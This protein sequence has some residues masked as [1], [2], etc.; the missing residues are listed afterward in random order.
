MGLFDFFMSEEKKI[1]KHQ[2]T[3]TNRDLAVEDR[4]VAARWLSDNGSPKSLV[5]LLTR[6]DVKPLTNQMH[7]ESER[8]FV[9]GLLA[10]NKENL[11]RPLKRHLKRCNKVAFPVRLVEEAF[12]EE[13][14]VQ[15]VM[16]ILQHELE[17][18]D[19]SNPEKKTDL[20]VWL[21][22]REHAGLSKLAGEYLKNF[23]EHVRCAA[24]EVVATLDENEVR[25]LLEGVLANS[26]EES[27]RLRARAAEVFVANDWILENPGAIGEVVGGFVVQGDRIARG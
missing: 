7:D 9:F 10:Q 1:Q 18:D 21:S 2:R 13:S 22:G 24:L 8:E 3:L 16:D 4:D 25:P 15:W 5:A 11:E 26:E 23:D 19:L 6:F 14:A 20:L 17:R 27:N 12:G